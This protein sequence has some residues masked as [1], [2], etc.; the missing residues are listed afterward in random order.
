[1][2]QQTLCVK[3][4]RAVVRVSSN[5]GKLIDF[6]RRLLGRIV[7]DD[8]EP[9]ANINIAWRYDYPFSAPG[10]PLWS[11][12]NEV[13]I[14]LF[15]TGDT[16]ALPEVP[17]FP[18]LSVRYSCDEHVQVDAQV[19]FRIPADFL[20][21][22]LGRYNPTY[23]PSRL[24]YHALYFPAAWFLGTHFNRFWFHAAALVSDGRAI[25]IGGLAGIGKTTLCARL[26]QQENIALLSD[27]MV[28]YDD[29]EI[30]T[31][32]EPMRISEPTAVPGELVQVGRLS[33][34]PAY[35]VADQ[36]IGTARPAI[37][38]LPKFGQQP[39]IEKLPSPSAAHRLYTASRT[40]AQVNE[41]DYYARMLSAYYEI[42]DW[43]PR[44][45]QALETL[46]DGVQ[47]YALT[48][49]RRAGPE[50]AHQM[51]MEIIDEVI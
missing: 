31:C 5:N 24:L 48:L 44:Q 17:G 9:D 10:R 16:V 7:T 13:A 39:A 6:F 18:R 46:L 3:I 1:M 34:K 23:Y 14:G 4:D 26:M 32:Y 36:V 11:G 45:L 29:T 8:A 21:C 30:A 37:V 49:S 27:D 47:C 19:S 33:N 43:F 38:I 12:L 25:V 22:V 40:A 42:D 15:G 20:R 50:P 35:E 41:F 2:S 28:F 51:L